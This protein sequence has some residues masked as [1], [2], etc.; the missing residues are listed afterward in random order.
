MTPRVILRPQVP[1]DLEAIIDYLADRNPAAATRFAESVHATLED[2]SRMPG[3]GSP[4]RFRGKR[5]A[6]IRSWFV[7]GF[8]NYLILY[9]PVDTGIEVLAVLHGARQLAGILR[10]RT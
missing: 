4:K 3:K 6:G 9:R 8:P 5:L 1:G 7:A 2:L 10:D